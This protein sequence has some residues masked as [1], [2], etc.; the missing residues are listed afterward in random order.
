M[1]AS[2]SARGEV[3][4]GDPPGRFTRVFIETDAGELEARMSTRGNW[5][6]RLRAA[7]EGEW[8]LACRGDLDCGAEATGPDALG[9]PEEI[10]RG[11]LRIEPSARTVAIDGRPLRFPNKEFTILCCLAAQPERVVG[12]E[13]LSKAV[14]GDADRSRRRA[15]KSHVCRLRRRLRAAGADGLIVN[16][17]SAGYRLWDQPT[18]APRIY[19]A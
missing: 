18:P 12:L 1:A 6:L 10:V 4:P 16:F 7:E 19:D 11:P 14:Y 2:T 9:R 17:Y 13:E 8:R 5:E 15:L 3:R